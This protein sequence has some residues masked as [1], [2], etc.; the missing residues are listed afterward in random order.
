MPK[1]LTIGP[2]H[3]LTQNTVYALPSR[4]VRG[5]AF[6]AGLTL[7]QANDEAFASA[8]TLTLT[9]GMFNSAGVFIR[10]TAAGDSTL[11]LAA[12]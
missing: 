6:G 2:V 9:D 7:Q 5:F 4:S 10:S 1:L 8:T 12:S 3:T 11:K